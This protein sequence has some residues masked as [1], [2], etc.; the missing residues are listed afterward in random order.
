VGPRARLYVMVER[1]L[2]TLPGTEPRLLDHPARSLMF[3]PTELSQQSYSN[4]CHVLE[5]S[6]PVFYSIIISYVLM[7]VKYAAAK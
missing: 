1:N 4:S 5:M 6:P 3:I 2:L 7:S